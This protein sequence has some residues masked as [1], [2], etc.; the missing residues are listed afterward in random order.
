MKKHSDGLPESQIRLSVLVPELLAQKFNKYKIYEKC[1]ISATKI[2]YRMWDTKREN[3]RETSALLQGCCIAKMTFAGHV[4]LGSSGDS[5]RSSLE[6]KVV[7]SARKTEADV[8]WI[9]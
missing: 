7:K 8:D 3:E 2:E 5:A 1:W 6:D 4:L 9:D